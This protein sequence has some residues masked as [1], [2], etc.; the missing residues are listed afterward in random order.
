MKTMHHSFLILSRLIC[1]SSF[2]AL[3]AASTLSALSAPAGDLVIRENQAAEDF[4]LAYP[5]GNGRLGAMPFG[6]FPQER[7]LLNEE[8]IWA[9]T[10]PM[11]MAE[12]LFP[13]LEKVRELEAAGDYAAADKYFEANISGSGS[14]RKSPHSYQPRLPQS[15]QP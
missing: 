14:R 10:Q 5:V 11:F 15:P 1:F 9:N 7:I 4:D 2:F 3:S 12:N 6:A 13:H 8:S